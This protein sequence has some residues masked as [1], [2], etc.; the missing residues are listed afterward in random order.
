M[1]LFIWA[2]KSPSTS[3][4][5][6]FLS[7]LNAFALL[8]NI[9]LLN[10]HGYISGFP[11]LFNIYIYFF[12]NITPS[13]LCGCSF[14][15]VVSDLLRPPWTIAH[16]VL[17]SVGFPRQEYSSGLPFPSPGDLPNPRNPSLLSVLHWQAGSLP[18]NHLGSPILVAIVLKQV[19]K[20]GTEKESFNS[21]LFLWN[22]L[23]IP[24]PLFFPINF[25]I[26]LSISTKL[27][28]RISVG[29]P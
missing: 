27:L 23:V 13:W 21:A 18:L 20:L 12:T 3:W 25:K 22:V 9:I 5:K 4:G 1:F 2:S 28:I 16:E 26:C 15:S 8:S 29:V 14:A 11:C 17:L 24:G 19:L 7:H 6:D 10:W